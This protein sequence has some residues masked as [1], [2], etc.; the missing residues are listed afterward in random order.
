MGELTVFCNMKVMLTHN[1]ATSIGLSKGTKGR[2]IDWNEDVI[3]FKSDLEIP[4]T[5]KGLPA[6]V[7]PIQRVISRFNFNG[8]IKISRSQFPIIPAY[9]LTDYRAQGDTYQTAIID[10]RIPPTGGWS[11]YEAIYVMLSRV[12]NLHGLFILSE[13][14]KKFPKPPKELTDEYDRLEKLS[15]QNLN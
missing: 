1:I 4:L 7:V 8:G 11:S 15:V 14:E 12:S 10:L 3:F 2:V 13:F 5:F 6:N 9:S